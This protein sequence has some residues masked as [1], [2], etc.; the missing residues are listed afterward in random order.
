MKE[1]ERIAEKSK[2]QQ[3]L[4]TYTGLTA[5]N[6][7]VRLNANRAYIGEGIMT[8]APSIDVEIPIVRFED[9]C[10][11]QD[12]IC[13]TG[14]EEEDPRF[15][16]VAKMSEAQSSGISSGWDK[17]VIISPDRVPDWDDIDLT[18]AFY[19]MYGGGPVNGKKYFI[20]M[21][22]IDSVSGLTG[23]PYK[24]S[25]VCGDGSQITG[26]SMTPRT[27]FTRRDVIPGELDHLLTLDMEFAPGSTLISVDCQYDT[28]DYDVAAAKC[29]ISDAAA[30]RTPN[31]RAYVLSRTAPDKR[32]WPGY[33]EIDKWDWG[34]DHEISCAHRGGC[35]E[36][37]GII[38]G[39]SPVF[40]F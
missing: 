38:F 34:R 17:A 33:Y 13:F 28:K 39:T 5:H 6:L 1:L 36:R 24:V 26:Q 16:L 25:G 20:E 31:F 21:Y 10:L 23:I 22:W 37:Q 12:S 8:D 19:E 29:N 35:F 18:D 2:S 11:S 4:G 30:A 7:F 32:L 27:R 15:L 3:V 14:V 9:W 40:K